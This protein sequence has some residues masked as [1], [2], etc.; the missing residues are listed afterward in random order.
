M[1][2]LFYMNVPVNSVRKCEFISGFKAPI[3][4]ETRRAL[5]SY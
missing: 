4:D 1:R 5:W 3:N 2:L